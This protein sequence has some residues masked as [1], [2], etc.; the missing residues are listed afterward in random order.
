MKLTLG[1]KQRLFARMTARLYDFI[2]SKGYEFTKGD[3]YR[4]PKL[5]GELGVKKGYGHAKSGHKLRLA[6]DINLFKDIDGDG[7]LD[8]LEKTEYHREIGEF[9][10]S[11]GGSWGGRFQDGNHYS[12]EHEGVR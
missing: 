1:Q 8:Y 5:H 10:E 9:W 2:W 7:D 4:D 3:A 6:E 12:I 11:L